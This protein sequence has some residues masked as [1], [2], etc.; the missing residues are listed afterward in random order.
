MF[1]LI[2]FPLFS[3]PEMPE[4]IFTNLKNHFYEENEFTLWLAARSSRPQGLQLCSYPGRYSEI[5]RKDRPQVCLSA[6]L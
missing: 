6:G 1:V 3:I 5:T 4:E 2:Y